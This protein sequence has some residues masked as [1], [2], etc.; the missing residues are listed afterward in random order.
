M[1]NRDR[2]VKGLGIRLIHVFEDEWRDKREIVKRLLLSAIGKTEKLNAR[3]LDL[4]VVDGGLAGDFMDKYHIQG[5]IR[6]GF[7]AEYVGLHLDG[8]L[9]ACMG[10]S[11]S[12]SVRSAVVSSSTVEL[13]RYA[14]SATVRGGSSRLLTYFLSLNKNYKEIIS[15]SE[16]RL[17]SGNMYRAL[18]F[19]LVGCTPPD[20]SYVRS[21]SKPVRHNKSLFQRKHL[22]K[23]LGPLFNP[24]KTEEENC[25]S[26]GWF[27]VFDTGKSK[28]VLTK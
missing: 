23:R 20:Y 2:V 6:S 16:N 25:R 26:A 3:S 8:V 9:V 1:L 27:Q 22:P 15:Y 11:R 4:S 10:F 19:S 21:E 18:G 5:R 28:W 7:F 24:L 13:R 12:T 14:S 17:Y